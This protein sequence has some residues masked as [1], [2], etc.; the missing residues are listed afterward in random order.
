M[1][2]SFILKLSTLRQ[3]AFILLAVEI[4]YTKKISKQVTNKKIKKVTKLLRKVYF[5]L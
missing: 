1:P 5:L 3:L 4:Y 2:Q